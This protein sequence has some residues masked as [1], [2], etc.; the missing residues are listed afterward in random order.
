MTRILPI[1]TNIYHYLTQVCNFKYVPF[2]YFKY[3][4]QILPLSEV[5][6]SCPYG[7]TVYWVS[8]DV[9]ARGGLWWIWACVW[10]D[11]PLSTTFMQDPGQTRNCSQ[12]SSQQ[13]HSTT[14]TTQFHVNYNR[15]IGFMEISHV[16][17]VTSDFITDTCSFVV[18]SI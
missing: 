5:W 18:Q 17:N 1:D 6:R 9:P 15:R 16:I 12:H 4:Q 3:M 11:L 13:L 10:P 8:D 7:S 2:F 14:T